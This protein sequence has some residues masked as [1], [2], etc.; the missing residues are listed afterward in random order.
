MTLI[1][2]FSLNEGTRDHSDLFQIIFI[3]MLCDAQ[4][5]FK[6]KI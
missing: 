4:F 5:V 3:D 2:D 6:N 1:F